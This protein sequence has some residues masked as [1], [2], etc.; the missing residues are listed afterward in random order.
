MPNDTST[1]VKNVRARKVRIRC[2]RMNARVNQEGIQRHTAFCWSYNT[3]A[4][5]LFSSSV[6][7]KVHL[8]LHNDTVRSFDLETRS[9]SSRPPSWGGLAKG[10]FDQIGSLEWSAFRET[11]AKVAS[12]SCS[13]R[14]DFEHE[15]YSFVESWGFVGFHDEIVSWFH[16]VAAV[17]GR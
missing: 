1:T 7:S 13:V 11:F 8:M 16:G 5:L 6:G 3:R 2:Q 15:I 14:G 12:S 10:C 4:V 17:C 9:E